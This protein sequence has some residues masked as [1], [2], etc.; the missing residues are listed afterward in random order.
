MKIEIESHEDH[1]RAVRFLETYRTPHYAAVAFLIDELARAVD[2]YEQIHWPIGTPSPDAECFDC[3]HVH[4]GPVEPSEF[5]EMPAGRTCVIGCACKV[6][7]NW[8]GPV[9]P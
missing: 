3:G 7:Q 4:T 5:P 1:A 9:T 6:R 2:E 8:P